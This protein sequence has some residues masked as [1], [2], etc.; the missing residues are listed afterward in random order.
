M[1]F[2]DG[3]HRGGFGL[4]FMVPPSNS[5]S[6]DLFPKNLLTGQSDEQKADYQQ[7]A[8]RYSCEQSDPKHLRSSLKKG[9]QDKAGSQPEKQS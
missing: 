2:K 5:T 8:G 3:V 7:K 1:V 9:C 6:I 4:R